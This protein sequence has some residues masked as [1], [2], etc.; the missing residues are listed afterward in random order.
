MCGYFFYLFSTHLQRHQKNLYIAFNNQSFF[1]FFTSFVCADVKNSAQANLPKLLLPAFL[2]EEKYG[3]NY[4]T[5]RRNCQ[6]FF[7]Y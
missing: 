4:I 6:L 5:A 7:E 1:C 2:P 3:G